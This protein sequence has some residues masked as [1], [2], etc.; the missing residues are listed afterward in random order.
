MSWKIVVTPRWCTRK[1]AARMP[2][3]VVPTHFGHHQFLCHTKRK[4]L[5]HLFLFH[6]TS[7]S[8]NLYPVFSITVAVIIDHQHSSFGRWHHLPG[9]APYQQTQVY[10]WWSCCCCRILCLIYKTA[11]QTHQAHENSPH[12][13]AQF[14]CLH[15]HSKHNELVLPEK[16]HTHTF[17]LINEIRND[18]SMLKIHQLAIITSIIPRA[19]RLQIWRMRAQRTW[20]KNMVRFVIEWLWSTWIDYH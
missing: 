7:H 6:T 4:S 14:C 13:D 15:T 12:L 20:P 5:A 11:W 8:G 1:Y 9:H 17:A 3:R 16:K 10:L 19:A 2:S 18:E